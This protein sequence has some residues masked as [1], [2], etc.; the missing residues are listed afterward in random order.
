MPKEVPWGK[1]ESPSHLTCRDLSPPSRVQPHQETAPP[2]GCLF[3]WREEKDGTHVQRSSFLA[4]C[5]GDQFLS[6][7]TLI[8]SRESSSNLGCLGATE[9]E[10]EPPLPST[11]QSCRSEPAVSQTDT[12]G[13]S[14]VETAHFL[15]REIITRRSLKKWPQERFE[16]SILSNWYNWTWLSPV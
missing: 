9:K 7:L 6:R 4:C 10:G 1:W 3:L 2:S 13:R 8:T 16:K 14:W 5:P 12:K 11:C 15:S